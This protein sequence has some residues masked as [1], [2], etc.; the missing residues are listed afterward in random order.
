MAEDWRLR[1]TYGGY[2]VYT[3]Q[4]HN[5]PMGLLPL[6]KARRRPALRRTRG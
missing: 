4:D 5:K 3:R 1:A 2:H 6:E